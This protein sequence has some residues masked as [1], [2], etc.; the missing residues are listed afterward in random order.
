MVLVVEPDAAAAGAVREAA[1]HER[2]VT[3]H[4]AANA[5]D[6]L[7]T[8]RWS[9]PDLLI[10]GG[11]PPDAS[12]EEVGRALRGLPGASVTMTVF[13]GASPTDAPAPA[14]A[15]EPEMDLVLPRAPAPG[16]V[17]RTVRLAQRLKAMRSRI[18]A[19]AL[20]LVRL[21]EVV[22]RG[23]QQMLPLLQRLIELG[24]PGANERGQRIAD[25][26]GRI[27]ARFGVP[28]RLLPDLEVAARLHEIGRLAAAD[29][30]GGTTPND[31]R[32]F[33]L[34]SRALLSQ[35][36]ALQGAAEV[37]GGL[38]ENWD[39]SGFPGHLLSGQIPLR[40]RILRVVRDF[41][42]AMESPPPDA[43]AEVLAALRER[44]GT[45]YDPVV[46]VHLEAVAQAADGATAVGG[47]TVVAVT[48]L[49]PGMVL[50]ED[51]CTDGGL[52]L[53][54]RETVL[55]VPLLEM[56]RRRHQLEPLV[57]GATVRRDPGS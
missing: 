30:A 9:P 37:V 50:A 46:V 33:V 39:G 7:T 22:G 32:H 19:D 12:R 53:L 47:S 10:L 49:R 5:A 23:V 15:D 44:V 52:K 35:V 57:Q 27:A 17:V 20:E 16:A 45:W 4:V 11:P 41:V 3:V 28:T 26:A 31:A 54:A 14:T 38:F 1:R 40:S 6:G 55:T 29:A 13:L 21:R 56:I 18:Q 42:A 24:V 2:G 8:A 34:F 43:A 51:L 36:D 48:A 25:L